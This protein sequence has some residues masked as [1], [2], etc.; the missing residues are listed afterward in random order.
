MVSAIRNFKCVLDLGLSEEPYSTTMKISETIYGQS[1]YQVDLHYT[2]KLLANEVIERVEG[3]QEC[4]LYW[5]EI[6][7][8]KR[9]Q[10]YVRTVDIIS[11]ETEFFNTGCRVGLLGVDKFYSMQRIRK[12]RVFKNKTFKEILDVIASDYGLK[13]YTDVDTKKLHVVQGYESD[14][15]LIVKSLIPQA[16][17]S[18]FISGLGNKPLPFIFYIDTIWKTL[19]VCRRTQIPKFPTLKFSTNPRDKTEIRS[20]YMTG[21]SRLETGHYYTVG[22]GIDYIK[23]PFWFRE[24]NSKKLDII[25]DDYYGGK[26]VFNKGAGAYGSEPLEVLSQDSQ[27]DSHIKGHMPKPSLFSKYRLSIIETQSPKQ[28]LG[29]VESRPLGWAVS[30]LRIL[31]R[32][33]MPWI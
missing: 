5:F 28:W 12:G 27:V 7:E 33:T 3:N 29:S 24:F 6:F 8:D 16:Q 10:S 31:L 2:N 13:V 22:R 25:Y 4:S 32:E 14:Y 11:M 17:Q 9:I 15:D 30:R 19:V 18:I 21:T 20:L 26:Q 1:T 23:E